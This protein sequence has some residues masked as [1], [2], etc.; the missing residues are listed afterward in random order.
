MHSRS[1]PL[2]TFDD[3]IEAAKGLRPMECEGYVVVDRHFNRIKVKSPQ[4]VA[5]SHLKE[6]MSARRLLEIVRMNERD[7]FLA[8]FPEWTGAYNR[9]RGALDGLIAELE[10][11]YQEIVH[12]T[13][14]KDFAAEALKTRCSAALF[15][16]RAGKS[17]S[18]R[19]YLASATFG[20][21]ERAVEM[22]MRAME[23][24]AE[25]AKATAE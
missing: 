15:S 24:E 23:N 3:G 17:K 20:S 2:S 8:H 25:L 5:L 19:E 16:L 21:V 12:L 6:G 18:I 7:E 11:R 1:F 10:N 9:V 13:A 4:Y 14:Q 22:E